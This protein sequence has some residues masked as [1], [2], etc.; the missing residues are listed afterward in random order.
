M[1][2][3]VRAVFDLHKPQSVGNVAFTAPCLRMEGAGSTC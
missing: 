3:S 2:I 1:K